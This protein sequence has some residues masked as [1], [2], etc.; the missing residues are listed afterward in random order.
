[1]PPLQQHYEL[2]TVAQRLG[3]GK[4][5]VRAEI[6]AGRIAPVQKLGHRTIRIPQTAIDRYLKL[7]QVTEVTDE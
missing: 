2:E 4:S 6:R 1:M 3:I 7:T 5:T